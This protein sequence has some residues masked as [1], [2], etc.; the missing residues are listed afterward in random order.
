MVADYRATFAR[1]RAMRADV[2]LANHG[3][4]FGLERRRARQLAGDPNAFVDA[5]A[6]Q[7][8][9]DEMEAAFSADLARQ[10]QAHSLTHES[11][12]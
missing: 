10:R 1:V 6:L 5:S 4:L 7:R 12:E 11:S 2:F 8:F 3:Q 9:N